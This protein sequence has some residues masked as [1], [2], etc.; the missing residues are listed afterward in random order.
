MISNQHNDKRIK[1]K[2][3]GPKPQETSIKLYDNNGECSSLGLVQDIQ[4][5][6]SVKDFHK[7]TITSILEDAELDFLENETE[8]KVIYSPLAKIIRKIKKI[9]K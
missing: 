7:L 9:I 6:S 4:V 2:I 8:I 5:N 3:S 1:I